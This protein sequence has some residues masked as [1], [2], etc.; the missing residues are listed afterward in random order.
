MSESELRSILEQMRNEMDV[1]RS[2]DAW[3]YDSREDVL[4][5][6]RPEESELVPERDPESVDPKG[7]EVYRIGRGLLQVDD[8]EI[9]VE[10]W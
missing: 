3:E 4:V 6:R 7:R 9:V 2:T 5:N 8:D 10:T 1:L